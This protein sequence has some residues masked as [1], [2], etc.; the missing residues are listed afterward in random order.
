MVSLARVEHH[1]GMGLDREERRA[2]FSGALAVILWSTVATAFKLGLRQTSPAYLLAGA[3]LVSTV[4]LG[5]ILLLRG[6]LGVALRGSNERWFVAL[7]HGLVNPLAYYL[8]LFSAYDRLPAHVALSLNYTWPAALTLLSLPLAARRPT[9]SQWLGLVLAY[10]GVLSVSLF[11][12]W[13]GVALDAI[14]LALALGS[15]GLWAYYWMLRIK[16]RDDPD[17]SLFRSFL[18]ATP[19]T[20]LVALWTDGI[21]HELDAS[22]LL[23]A[24]YIGLFEMGVTFVLYQSAVRRIRRIAT[25]GALSFASPV[26]SVILI[27]TILGEPISFG[28]SCGMLLVLSGVVLSAREK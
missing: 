5:T 6:R 1:G 12:S 16:Q 17:L 15:S 14:G 21:P 22:P 8:V 11:S 24:T 18:V 23:A 19:I 10:T 4:A 26:L 28:A 2:F 20:V 7:H 13:D 27:A 9:R 3:S 25:L